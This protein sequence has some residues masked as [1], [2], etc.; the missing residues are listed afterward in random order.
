MEFNN[1]SSLKQ[2]QYLKHIPFFVQSQISSVHAD[3]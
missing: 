3:G 1:A 2:Q